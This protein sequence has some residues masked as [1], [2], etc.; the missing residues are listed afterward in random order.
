MMTSIMGS[1]SGAADVT[2][3]A[4]N[5]HLFSQVHEGE[6]L[7]QAVDDAPHS[8][9]AADTCHQPRVEI[10]CWQMHLLALPKKKE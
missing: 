8:S 5:R 3:V 7:T 1:C 4:R 2:I 6:Q 9:S 10:L